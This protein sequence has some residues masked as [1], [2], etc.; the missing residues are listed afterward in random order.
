MITIRMSEYCG[1]ESELFLE[2][3]EAVIQISFHVI[4]ETGVDN[5]DLLSGA[6]L[7]G[8]K[9]AAITLSHIQENQF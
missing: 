8:G 3:S 2:I 6:Y 5:H 9:N 7:R 1:V 4:A